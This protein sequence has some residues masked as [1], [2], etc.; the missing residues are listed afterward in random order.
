MQ[1]ERCRAD[2]GWT[3]PDSFQIPR[4][5]WPAS[6]LPSLAAVAGKTRWA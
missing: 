4:N 3:Y 6:S 2:N 1:E 5:L